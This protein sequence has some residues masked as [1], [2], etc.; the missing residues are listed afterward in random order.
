MPVDD[1]EGL[2]QAVAKRWRSRSLQ[3]A[4]GGHQGRERPSVVKP[5]RITNGLWA[6]GPH[7][8]YKLG[9]VRGWYFFGT[10]DLVERLTAL[11]M[12]IH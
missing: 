6:A 12:R 4:T 3:I 1:Q 7:E 8:G 5:K 2:E 11:C 10:D 9:H